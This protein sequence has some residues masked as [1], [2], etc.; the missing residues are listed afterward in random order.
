MFG[1]WMENEQMRQ[2]YPGTTNGWLKLGAG[3]PLFWHLLRMV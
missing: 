2:T 1:Q 3:V